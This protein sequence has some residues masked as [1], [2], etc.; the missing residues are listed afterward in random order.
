MVN[1][2]FNK[3]S[4][5]AKIPTKLS[6]VYCIKNIINNKVYI[7]SSKNIRKRLLEHLGIIYI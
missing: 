7:G 5:I 3:S 4:I 2:D 1:A 6:G